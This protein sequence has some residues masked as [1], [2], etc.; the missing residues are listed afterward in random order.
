MFVPKIS[1]TNVP[2][3]ADSVLITDIT[4]NTTDATPDTTGYVNASYAYYPQLNTIWHK[5]LKAQLLGT[6]SSQYYYD[7]L[8][9]KDNTS[10]ATG[11]I[12]LADGVWL[13]EEYW[14]RSTTEFT[15]S[16]QYTID[17]ANKVLTRTGGTAWLDAGNV[18]GLFSG[19]YGVALSNPTETAPNIKPI[20]G[21][22]SSTLTLSSA[23]S[24]SVVA[25]DSHLNL[26]YRVQKYMLVMNRGEQSLISDIGNLAIAELQG[27]GCNDVKIKEY[28]RRLILKLSAQIAFNCGQYAK[29][30]NCA[31][32]FS[33]SSQ[34]G[35]CS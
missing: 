17:A 25:S 34:T 27:Q 18:P 24:S 30:H 35:C 21:L 4:G 23:L 28:C 3:T 19:L 13:I 31:T 29:A 20:T 32:L 33:N 8:T 14:M 10:A 5:F 26:Y 16:L 9:D 7:P 2:L 15:V 6:L 11:V 1:L 22:T 12:D